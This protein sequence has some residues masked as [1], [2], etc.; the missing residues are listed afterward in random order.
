MLNF[1]LNLDVRTLILVLF[2]G[3][4]ASVGLICAF[5]YATDSG[6]DWTG[7]RHLLLAKAFQSAAYLLLLSRGFVPTLLSVNLGNSFLFIG[8]YYEAIA[9]L[10]ILNET[11]QSKVYLQTVLA[12]CI[13]GFN[14]IEFFY[15]DSSL[16]VA[17]SSI[18]A[19]LILALPCLRLFI[20]SNSGKFKQWVGVM[21]LCFLVM[22]FPRIIY[23]LTTKMSLLSNSSIQ[24]MTFL[25][26]VLLL[27]FCL[28]A[29][30][31]LIK[32]DTDQIIANMGTTDSLTGLANRQSFLEAAQRVFLRS[33]MNERILSILFIDIDFFKTINDTYGY[34][35]GDK[36]L[37][38]LGRSIDE[39]LRPTDLSGRYGGEEFV[40][41]LHDTDISDAVATAN[42]IRNTV[43]T[44][45]FPENPDF[46]F[47]LSIGV[48]DG[49]PAPDD[50]LDLFIGRADSALY[51]AKRAGRDRVV[52]YDPVTAFA[53]DI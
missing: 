52:E 35:F 40:I 14:C 46:R 12:L 28:P 21:Y 31:F 13:V 20:S 27:V 23:A 48:V 10:R 8:F 47:T 33:Q 16:R 49:T 22:L 19:L 30:L 51:M 15:P 18:C 24:T 44:L 53:S 34:S 36:L 43:G 9:M 50:S 4:L 3:N 41:L 25:A 1:F 11:K 39:C 45:S 6:R 37:A 26:L 29:Y 2:C 17:F 32:E 38:A 42:C 7:C 5:Y